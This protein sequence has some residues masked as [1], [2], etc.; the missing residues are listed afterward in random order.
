MVDA[1]AS[2]AASREW[3]PVVIFGVLIV[4]TVGSL[5]ALAVT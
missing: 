1:V 2:A 5:V 3:A 4:L